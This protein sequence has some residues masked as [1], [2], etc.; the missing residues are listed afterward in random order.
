VAADFAKDVFPIFQRACFECHGAELQKGKLR[1]D[2]REDAF[3]SADVIVKG[4][5]A[6]SELYQRII[7]PKGHDDIMPSRGEPLSKAQI[8]VI[9]AWIDAGAVWP[10]GVQA[11]KHWAYVAPTRPA[12][13]EIKR[14]SGVAG[15]GSDGRPSRY[16]QALQ[17]SS[18]VD[19]F[20][21]ARLH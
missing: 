1:L 11:P 6:K 5:A 13:P 2:R 17:R 4:D 19:A 3:K 10:E 15:K 18:P 9:K 14:S 8:V 16:T 20:V 12:V 7:L 21:A